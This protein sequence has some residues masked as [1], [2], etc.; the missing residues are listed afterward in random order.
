MMG[1]SAP[2]RRE[3]RSDSRRAQDEWRPLLMHNPAM[4]I[5]EFDVGPLRG[6]RRAAASGLGNLV[7]L[8]GPNGAG[9]SSLLDLLRQNRQGLA[10]PGTTVMFVGPH[11]T[12]R[13]SSLNKVSLFGYPMSSYGAL[14]QSDNLP[15]FQ[16]SVPAGMQGLQ[17]A[18][19][20]SGSADDAP[21]FVKTSLGRLRDRQ[22]TLVTE[23]W[24]KNGGHV[25][26]DSV[27][28][29]FEPFDRLIRNLLPHLAFVGVDDTNA[30]NIQVRFRAADGAGPEFDIDQLSSGEKAAI[31]LLLPLVE[32]QAEQLI[33]PTDAAPGV[34]P[35]TMLLDEPELHL[36][37]LLQLQVLQYLRD[38][39]A[40]GSA[41]FILSTHSPSLL[42]AL[43]DEELYLVSP[44]GMAADNQLSR[45]TTTHER[46]EVARELTG[47]THL[48]TRAKPIVF[49]EGEVER[50]GI[51]SDTRMIS[52]LLPKTKSW[53]L[54]PGRSKAEVIASVQRLRQEGLQLPG[55]PVF[56]LVDADTD[57]ASTD[58]YIVPW[59][60]TMV[61]N[62]LL[63]PE[64]IFQVLEPFGTQTRATSVAAVAAALEAAAQ[65]RVDEEVRLRV[66]RQ[67][68]VGRLSLKPDELQDAARVANLQTEAWLTKLQAINVAALQEAARVEVNAVLTAGDQLARFHGKAILR[69]TYG[70]LRVAEAGLGKAAFA[71]SLAVSPHARA[72]A[73]ALAGAAVDR[74]RL[75]FPQEL[76]EELARDGGYGEL[77]SRCRDHYEAWEAD[78][79]AADGRAHLREEIFAY[80]RTLGDNARLRLVQYASQIGTP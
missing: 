17:G 70:S 19:R 37:P 65:N 29:L 14:L 53:A 46:L 2:S 3:S 12:W 74:I 71:L 4:A 62:L 48:L 60:V 13:S 55:T 42:D 41:Q 22:Q 59:P 80:A 25:P 69:D 51:S 68:P 30:D 50:M 52:S 10:E 57:G 31:G 45:L 43:T 21:A 23:T 78:R 5:R 73:E 66:Q 20:D 28:N 18:M 33:A 7:V 27:A 61:E 39:A 15:H 58:S 76:G 47:A 6:L 54:V 56:G 49:I 72:R 9:K 75:Y 24:E 64:A 79:P 26:A 63:D 34:V 36:H 32:R 44:A 11:R 77:A 35:L 1:G 38:L 16:Y 67:L 40:D 8:A